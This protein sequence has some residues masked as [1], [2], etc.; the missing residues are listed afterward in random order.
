M[1]I[2]F[3][4]PGQG[5]QYVGMGKDV[6]ER[7]E[8]AREVYRAADRVTG[9]NISGMCF[10]GPDE[11]LIK[12]VNQQPTIHTTEIAILRVVESYGIRADVTAGFSLGE[13]AALVCAGALKFEDTV[14]LVVKRGTLIQECVQMGV[15]KMAAISGLQRAQVQEIAGRVTGSGVVECSNYNCPGQVIISGHNAAVD[16]GVEMAKA[17]GAKVTFLKV[18]APFH[19]SLLKEAGTKLHKE[20]NKVDV[21][22]PRITY[23]P[24]VTAKPYRKGDDI[25][26]LLDQHVAHAVMWEDTVYTMLELGVNVFVE[27][28]PG[29][30]ISKFNRRTIDAVGGDAEVFHIEN[31]DDIESFVSFMNKNS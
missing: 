12:T 11:E 24:N 10:Q 16:K 31:P 17:L 14:G 13:Y 8:A 19:T 2:A 30:G 4:F 20:L 6:F 7:Y 1:K 15:G 29:Q 9:K 3:V 27:I 25:R 18:S 26:T 28:G 21:L 23:I 22:E 5:S